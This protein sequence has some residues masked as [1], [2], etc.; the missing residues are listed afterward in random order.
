[1]VSSLGAR[2]S[3]DDESVLARHG[4]GAQQ[5][6]LGEDGVLWRDGESEHVKSSC[7]LVLSTAC[8]DAIDSIASP[9]AVGETFVSLVCAEKPGDE[10]WHDGLAGSFGALGTRRLN[11][12]T[13]AALALGVFTFRGSLVAQGETIL[14]PEIV[15]SSA[16]T[17]GAN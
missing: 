1:V 2:I 7:L 9:R 8:V 16:R 11:A 4:S 14:G 13:K 15:D 12:P 10:G 6:L 3:G 5:E 17:W